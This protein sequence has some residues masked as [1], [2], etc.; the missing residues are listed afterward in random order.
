MILDKCTN[1]K[2]YL[3]ISKELDIALEII[4]DIDSVKPIEG[5]NDISEVSYFNYSMSQLRD[6][7]DWFEFHKKYTDIHV[8]LDKDEKI[9]ICKTDSMPEGTEFNADTDCGF[10]TGK[11]VTT[12]NIPQ[13]WF[14]ICFPHDAHEPLLGDKNES[15]KKIVFKIPV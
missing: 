6:T 2:T 15:V 4:A 5:R 11:A 3:G 14:L 1:A 12:V 13:G 7:K 9:A 8:P 10:F